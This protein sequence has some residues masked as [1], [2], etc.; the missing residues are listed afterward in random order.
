[1]S[2]VTRRIVEAAALISREAAEEILFNH[3][4]LCQTCFPHRA[5]PE[6]TRVWQ[7]RQ[8][9]AVLHVQ[10][11]AAYHPRS[12]A[13]VEMGLPYG[14]VARLILMHLNTE[15]M[16]NQSPVVEVERSLTAF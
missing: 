16:R 2:K 14:A 1:M 12:G 3:S 5:P 8:G 9:R 7:Q 15:A 11:G 10:A 13:F 4:A 6:D